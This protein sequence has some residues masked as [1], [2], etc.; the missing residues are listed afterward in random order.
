M[1]SHLSSSG[2][3][4]PSTFPPENIQQTSGHSHFEQF[5][6]TQLNDSSPFLQTSLS[7]IGQ[8]KSISMNELRHRIPQ[9]EVDLMPRVPKPIDWMDTSRGF[10]PYSRESPYTST[11]GSPT[12][13]SK[14][15]SLSISDRLPPQYA[16]NYHKRAYLNNRIRSPNTNR[17]NDRGAESQGEISSQYHQLPNTISFSMESDTQAKGDRVSPCTKR[18]TIPTTVPGNLTNLPVS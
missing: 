9:R 7:G 14:V 2:S 4:V 6:K 13:A 15:Q 16:G 12:Q 17:I 8:Y 10:V 18:T 5:G 1:Q 11:Y 3:Y